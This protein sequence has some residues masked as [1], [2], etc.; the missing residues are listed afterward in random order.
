MKWFLSESTVLFGM[1]SPPVEFLACDGF[2]YL[3]LGEINA[4]Y[5]RSEVVYKD[6]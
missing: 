1:I 2:Q 5:L 6:E 3:L 4:N